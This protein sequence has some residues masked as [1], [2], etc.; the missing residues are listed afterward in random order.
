MNKKTEL[1]KLIIIIIC[2]IGLFGF[3]IYFYNIILGFELNSLVHGFNLGVIFSIFIYAV[4]KQIKIIRSL[5]K[6]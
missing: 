4:I 1:L 3:L 2:I 5:Q 6:E